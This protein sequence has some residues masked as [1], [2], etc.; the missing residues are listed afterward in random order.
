MINIGNPATIFSAQGTGSLDKTNG[1]TG[2]PRC[3]SFRACEPD[4]QQSHRCDS[5]LHVKVIS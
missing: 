1:P 4:R 5:D 2:L 3:G